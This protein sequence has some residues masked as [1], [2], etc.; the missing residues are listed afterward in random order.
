MFTVR[1]ES[2]GRYYIYIIIV[3]TIV[4][5]FTLLIISYSTGYII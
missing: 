4:P 2:K 3:Q 1:Q 5:A